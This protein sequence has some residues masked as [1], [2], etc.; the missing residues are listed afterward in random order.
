L[1]KIKD[2]HKGENPYSSNDR[3]GNEVGGRN[4]VMKLNAS[5]N[6][7]VLGNFATQG[8][9]L[10]LKNFSSLNSAREPMNKGPDIMDDRMLKEL[11]E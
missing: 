1:N 8:N 9:N 3:S 4:F 5:K 6:E 7:S 2:S 10:N 11:Q